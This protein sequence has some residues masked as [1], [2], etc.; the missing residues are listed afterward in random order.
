MELIEAVIHTYN[1]SDIDISQVEGFVRQIMGWREFVRGI[2]WSN[3]P[4][5][6]SLNHFEAQRPLPGYF[7]T[8]DTQMNCVSQAVRQSLDHSYAHH[9]QRLMVTG[10]FGLLTGINP[11]DMDAWYLGIYADALEWVQLPNTRGMSQFADGGLI[12]SKP[13]ISSGSYINKMSDYCRHCKYHVKTKTESDSCPFNAL[14]WAF[15]DRHRAKLG[16]NP[17]LSM[18]YRNWDRMES[19]TRS[20]TLNRA[21]SLLIDLENL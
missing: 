10:Q 2:Y 6:T 15:L 4:D 20:A 3:M 5:Y 9:I 17:R 13:Y 21:T 8:G 12:A 14:Y 7:W 11:D 18:A 19:E 16:R 1:N